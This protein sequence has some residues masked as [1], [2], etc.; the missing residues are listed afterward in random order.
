MDHRAKPERSVASSID[1]PPMNLQIPKFMLLLTA[2]LAVVCLFSIYY[3]QRILNS[4]LVWDATEA[5]VL[6]D[7]VRAHRISPERAVAALDKAFDVMD[8]QRDTVRGLANAMWWGSA[9]G[10]IISILLFSV[11]FREP[12]LARRDRTG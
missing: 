10:L 8:A 12:W 6:K 1:Y 3:S 5:T 4:Q 9:S 7:D 2:G 11:F